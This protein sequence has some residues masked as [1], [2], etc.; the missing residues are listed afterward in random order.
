MKNLK[1]GKE[2]STKLNLF[3]LH[4]PE[5]DIT[6]RH[7]LRA[8]TTLPRYC[9]FSDKRNE[10]AEET[11]S[12]LKE[13]DEKAKIKFGNNWRE[14]WIEK[15]GLEVKPESARA[16]MRGKKPIPLIALEKLKEMGFEQEIDLIMDRVGY[17]SSCTKEITK[18][19]GTLTPDI[20]YLAGLLLSDGHLQ[21][22]KRKNQNHFYY[23]VYLYSGDKSLLEKHITPI[24]ESEFDLSNIRLV[25]RHQAWTLS[26]KNKV[27]F[28]FFNRILGI[29]H[30][31]K[32]IKAKIPKIV[33]DMDPEKAIPFLAG[34]IDGDIGRHGKSMGGTFRSEKFVDDVI[35]YLDR[36][37][38]KATKRKSNTLKDGYI[39]NEFY[40]PK[41]QVHILKDNMAKVFLPKRSDRIDLLFCRDTKVV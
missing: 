41:K 34:L 16:W 22:T 5:E 20:L 33:W 11:I 18:V 39:Q 40:I 19:P 10:H 35:L 1:N 27:L 31:K 9:G 14:K 3:D 37:G 8:F 25:Y 36:L 7:C 4:N 15:I 6:I 21:G 23:A 32:S 2:D 24:I 30:G 13:V 26:K 12:I 28:R 29:P 17:I 38:V